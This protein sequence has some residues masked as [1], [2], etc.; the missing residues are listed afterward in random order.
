[1]Y[2][3]RIILDNKQSINQIRLAIVWW[4]IIGWAEVGIMWAVVC[5]SSEQLSLCQNGKGEQ[6]TEWAKNG[7]AV[8][9][10]GNWRGG[11]WAIV[12]QESWGEQLSGGQLTCEQLTLHRA[13]NVQHYS[14]G[15]ITEDYP[16]DH[17]CDA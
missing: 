10:V 17:V 9:I 15:N 5:I 4:A 12:G 13:S 6:M 8:D 3:L 7:W 1:M 11:K 16:T 14:V 2:S